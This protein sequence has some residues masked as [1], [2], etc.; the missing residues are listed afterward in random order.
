V[1]AI[2]GPVAAQ[3]DILGSHLSGRQEVPPISTGAHGF[4]LVTLHED[5]DRADWSLIYFGT[6]SAVGQAHI[7]FGTPGVNGGIMVFLCSN[8]VPAPTGV[9]PCP[10]G[11]GLNVLSGAITAADIGGAAAAQ[12]VNAGDF[13]AF[14]EALVESAAYV[15]VHTANFP[16]GEIRGSIDH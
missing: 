10:G 6:S 14:R 12:G 5:Q 4:F 13:S 1:L 15:N 9:A 2:A 11:P 8:L 7:H 3:I 16:N